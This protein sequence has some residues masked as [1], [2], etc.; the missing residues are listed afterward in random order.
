MVL[1]E[2]FPRDD[3]VSLWQAICRFY[4]E[5][6]PNLKKLTACALT[7]PVHTADCDGSF[8]VQNYIYTQRRSALTQEHWPAHEGLHRWTMLQGHAVHE[9]SVRVGGETP[10]L[11]VQ[12]GLGDWVHFK[13]S[14]THPFENWPIILHS[15]G[16][17]GPWYLKTIWSSHIEYFWICP[18]NEP[19]LTWFKPML[20]LSVRRSHSS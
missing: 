9:G 10:A 3:F 4:P 13:L 11:F 12:E 5:D 18:L 19:V 1:S 16:S 15:Y 8:S 17:L 14:L 6:F 7:L 2:L 20:N